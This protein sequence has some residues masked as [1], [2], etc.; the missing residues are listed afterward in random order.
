MPEDRATGPERRPSE[1]TCPR[2]EES[3]I[4]LRIALRLACPYCGLDLEDDDA[5]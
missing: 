4:A 5:S 1:R 2:C 3:T